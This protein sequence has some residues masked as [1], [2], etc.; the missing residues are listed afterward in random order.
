MPANPILAQLTRGGTQG[1]IVESIH[2]GSYAVVDAKG[3]LLKSSGDINLPIFPRSAIKALQGLPLIESGAADAFGLSKQEVAISCASHG[4]EARHIETIR[5]ILAK[6]GVGEENLECGSHWPLYAPAGRE[7]AV[8]GETPER[9]HNNCS[10]KHAGMLATAKHLG[11]PLEHYVERSHPVQQRIQSI[12]S[13][14]CEC[15]LINATCGVDGC[16]VPTWAL[17]LKSMALGFAKFGG[18]DVQDQHWAEPS[19]KI[20][21][22]VKANPFMVAGSKRFCTKIMEAVPRLFAKTGAEGVYCGAVPH[23]GIGIA[24]KCD[25]G[26]SRGAEVIFAKIAASLDIWKKEELDLFTSFSKIDLKNFNDKV[27]GELRAL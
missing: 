1:S 19:M 9:I 16:S 15:D 5:S 12:I 10:G 2:R 26:A 6:A 4:S 22:A 25:D 11:E 17:P 3:N 23:A 27:V 21:K 20:I 8:K 18:A 24:V 14:F 13:D 7:M